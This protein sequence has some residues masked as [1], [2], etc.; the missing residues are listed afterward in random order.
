MATE[1]VGGKRTVNSPGELRRKGKRRLRRL[2]ASQLDSFFLGDLLH[3][4]ELQRYSSE[5]GVALIIGAL[6]NSSEV[7]GVLGK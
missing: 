4:A 7:F 1:V 5:L 6:K 3:L 2:E